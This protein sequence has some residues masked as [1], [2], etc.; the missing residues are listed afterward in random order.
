[1][2]GTFINDHTGEEEDRLI[3]GIV[4]GD[5]D[6][7]E[8]KL[9]NAAKANALRPAHDA[10][11]ALCKSLG[12]GGDVLCGEV[13]G[14]EQVVELSDFSE[15]LSDADEIHLRGTG[16]CKM[17]SHCLSETAGIACVLA[18]EDASGLGGKLLDELGVK[19]LDRVHGKYLSKPPTMRSCL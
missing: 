1:M 11:S 13:E 7:E 6:I 19:R 9:Q 12:L 4:R 18:N 5:M 14:L 2:V 17:R 8:N 15:L 3:V 16:L 10:F